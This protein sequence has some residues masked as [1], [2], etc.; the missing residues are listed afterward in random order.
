[1]TFLNSVTINLKDQAAADNLSGATTTFGS[2]F[3]SLLGGIMFIAALLVLFYLIWGAIEWITA[4]GDQ[5]KIQK[6][7]DR[8]V[9][10]I[11]GII[12]LASTLALFGLVQSFLGLEVLNFGPPNPRSSQL[13]Q[14]VPVKQQVHQLADQVF[15]ANQIKT[16]RY[17][18]MKSNYDTIFL[19]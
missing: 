11:I 3:E 15:T 17:S 13:I 19:I 10:S 9:Q 4:G 5:S 6:G 16:D 14:S 2:F 18:Q 1:M 8:I 7:R 12:V